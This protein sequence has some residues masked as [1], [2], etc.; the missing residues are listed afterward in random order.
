MSFGTLV[1]SIVGLTPVSA[2]EGRQEATG[3]YKLIGLFSD[4]V[5][6]PLHSTK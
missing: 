3:T 2:L 4:G 6:L 1:C 5:N